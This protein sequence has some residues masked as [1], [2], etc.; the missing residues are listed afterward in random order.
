MNSAGRD[1]GRCNSYECPL[2][3]RRADADLGR[4][5]D[6]VQL[7]AG[8]VE[9]EWGALVL[10][11]IALNVD[12]VRHIYNRLSKSINRLQTEAAKTGERLETIATS[13]ILPW[14]ASG[15]GRRRLRLSR[16]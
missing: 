15:W 10:F 3:F 16:C 12:S 2:K 9:H 7:L 14:L 4:L 5:G 11:R 1:A 8:R 6:L 13:R